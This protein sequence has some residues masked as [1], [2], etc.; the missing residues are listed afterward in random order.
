MIH[1]NLQIHSL[2]LWTS[3]AF[4]ITSCQDFVEEIQQL[5]QEKKRKPMIVNKTTFL[6]SMFRELLVQH[7][8]PL[9]LVRVVVVEEEDN[10]KGVIAWSQAELLLGLIEQTSSQS[11]SEARLRH[12]SQVVRETCAKLGT[13]RRP[14]SA[15]YTVAFAPDTS[16][17]SLK[18]HHM[19]SESQ[20]L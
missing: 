18:S 10:G 5:H 17:H 7:T 15:A 16:R 4:D 19:S 13:R 8:A 12:A 11:I 9:A 20:D 6:L 3:N 2:T 14:R 1:I